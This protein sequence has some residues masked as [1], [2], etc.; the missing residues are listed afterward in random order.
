MFIVHVAQFQESAK[1]REIIVA[2]YP[3]VSSSWNGI[4]GGDCHAKK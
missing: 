4:R 3:P 1:N 2:F